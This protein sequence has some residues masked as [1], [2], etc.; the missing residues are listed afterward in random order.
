MK[1]LWALNGSSPGAGLD[2]RRGAVRQELPALLVVLEI[3]DHDLVEHLLVHGRVD[4]RAQHL[5]AAVEIARH[6]VG[7]RDVD[8]RLRVRQAVAVA[9]AVDAAVLEEAAD[10]RFDADVLGQ[11]RA[12][13]AAGSRCR[14]PRGRS[15]TPA[16][17]CLVERVDDV[18]IDQRSSS[19]SRSRPGARPWRARSPRRCA[20]GC[21]CA[22]SS[23]ETAMRLELG[24]LGIAGDEI[25]DAA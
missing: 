20:R 24:R 9:E 3:G 1:Y 8:R 11:A 4:D 6:H 7:R 16:L 19:S 13:P 2:A 10:D 25:E 14:A 23:G 22:V 12:R 18:G 17:R 5:D 15:A 21:A